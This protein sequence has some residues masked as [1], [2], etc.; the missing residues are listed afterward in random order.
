MD[1]EKDEEQVETVLERCKE[2]DGAI[3][4]GEPGRD[5]IEHEAQHSLHP[6][7]LISTH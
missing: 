1:K 6:P 4:M 5:G 3:N 7:I 2:I